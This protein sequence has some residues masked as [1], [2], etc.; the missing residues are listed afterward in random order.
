[1]TMA[2]V[3]ML[4]AGP[5]AGEAQDSA[6]RIDALI[7][8]YL[9][10]GKFNGSV[11]VAE[12][13]QVILT[14]G[15]GYANFEWDIPCTPDTKFRLGSI[16][17]QFTA[18]LILRQVERGKIALDDPMG[19]YL[20]GYPKH[21]AERVT[22]R[23]LLNHTSGIPNYTEI[24]SPRDPH[25]ARVPWML[26]SLIAVFSGLPLEFEPETR[27]KYSNSGYVLLGKILE[28]L[29]GRSYERLLQEEI[30]SPLGMKNTGYDHAAPILPKRAA[31]YER[32]GGLKN[33]EYLDMSI[34]HAAGAMYS[35]VEDLLIWDQALYTEKLL[36]EKWKG[37]YFRPGLSDYAL[38]WV[39][40]NM[41]A[42]N[43][44][45][46]VWTISHGGG[47]NG[48]NTLIVRVPEKRQLIVILNNT[49]G[50]PLAAM[51]TGILGILHGKPYAEPKQSAAREFE[52]LIASDGMPSALAAFETMKARPDT[53]EVNEREIND[54]GYRMLN[55]GDI[56]AAITVF[57]VNVHA[58][59]KSW[60][61]YD[62]LGEA[63]AA[64]GRIDL[65]I[66]NYEKSLELNPK[67]TGGRKAL[68]DL[69]ARPVK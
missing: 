40:R 6:G 47:I 10:Y 39:V 35:T 41:A 38:G 5:A 45:D 67:N 29:T 50:A 66:E 58:F 11:L 69:K 19:K 49:G 16:T 14:K 46:S 18:M 22:V 8:R 30:L 34:P 63:L 15:Y 4:A 68:Q 3:V 12:N 26:D 42:G 31:G 2:V 20:P 56:R 25:E 61:V 37:E 55:G 28:N 48:F 24:R 17:K 36:S 33:A 59:P 9:D 1:M 43:G 60:N 32:S 27:M 64:D 52:K 62:S 7:T 51:A 65:A 57:K 53:Y 44:G 21:Q 23:Q 54:L 13:G